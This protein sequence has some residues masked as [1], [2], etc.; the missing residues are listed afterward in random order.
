MLVVDVLLMLAVAA[1]SA[2]GL[3]V[4][5]AVIVFPVAFGLG[6]QRKVIRGLVGG[7]ATVLVALPFTLGASIA[8]HEATFDKRED[9]LSTSV[10]N[11]EASVIELRG[12]LRAG[13]R[14][15]AVLTA[16]LSRLPIA[17]SDLQMQKSMYTE[18]WG[19]AL[20]S[21]RETVSVDGT[22]TPTE[23]L[24][25]GTVARATGPL[26]DFRFGGGIQPGVPRVRG[27]LTVGAATPVELREDQGHFSVERPT[28]AP[29][30]SGALR[31]WSV[32]VASAQ[33]LASALSA[34]L[35]I[36]D[37]VVVKLSENAQTEVEATVAWFDPREYPPSLEE[38]EL[39]VRARPPLEGVLVLLWR[40]GHPE[41]L[42]DGERPAE[43]ITRSGPQQLETGEGETCVTSARTEKYGLRPLIVLFKQKSETVA[44]VPED[45]GGSPA[46]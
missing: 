16:G 22:N 35:D 6:P 34:S 4:L 46:M 10:K 30:V 9:T 33:K 18:A 2:V 5:L 42:P 29:T 26:V 27:W 20:T 44:D 19:L 1:A 7:I 3:S 25:T 36:G 17:M 24:L 43:G 45:S 11:V 23:S 41:P 8:G 37:R 13:Q 38:Y 31:H 32:T 15:F 14:R 12:E 40:G 28:V 21:V 39:C